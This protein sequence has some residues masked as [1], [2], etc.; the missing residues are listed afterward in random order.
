M[1][2]KQSVK[3]KRI[4]DSYVPILLTFTDAE[5]SKVNLE[6]SGALKELGFDS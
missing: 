3:Y 2:G 4:Y 5:N 6:K 1:M